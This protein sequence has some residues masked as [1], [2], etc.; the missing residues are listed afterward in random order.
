MID[1]L[2]IAP[3]QYDDLQHVHGLRVSGNGESLCLTKDVASKYVVAYK[4][5]RGDAIFTV[6]GPD[7]GGIIQA[8]AEW[9][10]TEFKREGDDGF[11]QLY[12]EWDK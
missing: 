7:D 6:Y 12:A 9:F 4:N 3:V 2:P 5:A 10:R 1:F 8:L 11:N